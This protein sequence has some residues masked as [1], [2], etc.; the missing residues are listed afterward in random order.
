MNCQRA[1]LRVL[2]RP[3]GSIVNVSSGAG[4]KAVASMPSYSATKWGMRGLSK[5]AA[6]EFGPMGIRVNTLM[7]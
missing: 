5:T 6:A 3:G 7:P 1:Q 2:T 4:L